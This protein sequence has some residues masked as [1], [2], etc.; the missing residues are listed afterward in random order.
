MES[1]IGEYLSFSLG[2]SIVFLALL[3][4]EKK[5]NPKRKEKEK[6]KEMKEPL[7][8][9]SWKDQD[10]QEWRKNSW[11]FS[12]FSFSFVKVDGFWGEIN[13]GE[14]HQEKRE[15]KRGRKKEEEEGSKT[16][17]V[18]NFY[19]YIKKKKIVVVIP[20]FPFVLYCFFRA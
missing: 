4:K 10:K 1:K 15:K 9:A 6:E 12:G 11:C 2:G 7:P 8:V 5:K 13:S 17:G 18:K 14:S 20:S 16:K 3:A 19:I